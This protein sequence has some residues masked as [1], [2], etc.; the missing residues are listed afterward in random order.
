MVSFV[1]TIY[2]NINNIEITAMGDKTVFKQKKNSESKKKKNENYSH[3]LIYLIVTKHIRIYTS[4]SS[5]SHHFFHLCNSLDKASIV[6]FK[7]KYLHISEI[8]T[9]WYIH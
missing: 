1:C 4:S 3:R 9:Y 6:C 7:Y 2:I 5:H 8:F